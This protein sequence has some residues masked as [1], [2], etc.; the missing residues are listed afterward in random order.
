MERKINQKVAIEEIYIDEELYPRSSVYWQTYFKYQQSML[1]GAK[2]PR[3]VLAVYNGKKYLVDG[4]HR[5]E[6][7]KLNK[8]THIEAEVHTGWNK[9][10]IF[11]EAIRLNVAHGQQL[12]PYDKRRLALKLRV[13]KYPDSKI[14]KLVQIPLEKVEDFVAERLVNTL[15][16]DVIVKSEIK[17]L[18]GT[19]VEHNVED[20]QKQLKVENQQRLLKELIFLLEKKLMDSSNE[21]INE[22]LNKVRILLM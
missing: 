11:E 14:S 8:E 19:K 15:T 22:L 1:A 20:M 3:I 10:K 6:A 9:K 12:S 17:H 21:K 2:F 18:A 4:R 13:M 7:M 5:T 16:G